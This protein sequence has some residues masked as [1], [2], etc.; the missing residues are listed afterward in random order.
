M[1]KR[2]LLE[3][4]ITYREMIKT[5]VKIFFTQKYTCMSCQRQNLNTDF[6]NGL[7]V[8]K[9]LNKDTKEDGLSK[10]K[11]RRKG[12]KLQ[13]MKISFNTTNKSLDTKNPKNELCFNI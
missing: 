6:P 7:N 4:V 2:M 12:Y 10:H 11:L 1:R 5:F 3:I 13:K 8:K 9:T